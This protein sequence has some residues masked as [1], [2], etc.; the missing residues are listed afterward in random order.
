M[1][2]KDYEYR[3]GIVEKLRAMNYEVYPHKVE[4]THTVKEIVEKQ[5]E[6]MGSKVKTAGRIVGYREHGK[7]IF[8]DIF[9]DGF[10]VQL[11]VKKDVLQEDFK[12]FKNYVQRGDFVWV[13]GEVTKSKRGELS[14][15][16]EEF[17]L[18]CKAL[19]DLPHQWFGLENVETRYRK[20][21][22]DILLN[23]EVFETF[24]KRDLIIKTIR[25]EL[26]AMGFMEVTTPILQPV[27]GGAYAKP[28][29]TYVNALKKEYYL[30]ISPELYLK[31]LL[32][33]GYSKVFE[34]AQNFRNEDIDAEHN[35]EFTMIEIYWAY[36]DYNDMMSLTE[37]LIKKSAES[38]GVKEINF[39]GHKI[40]LRNFRRKDFY[41]LLEEHGIS[42]DISDEKIQQLLKEYKVKIP[43]Y[44]RGYALGKL[45][46]K[47]CEESLIQPTFVI[48]YPQETTPLCKWHRAKGKEIVERF[49][50][51]IGG[52][53]I[54]NGYTELND[55]E[56]QRE[57]FEEEMKRKR[58]GDE[59]AHQYDE[60]FV[61]ALR[62]GMP[63]AGGV[64]I[65]IDRL[66]MILTEKDSIKEVILYPMLAP[67]D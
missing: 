34:I 2:R 49:E 11:M 50:L 46:E 32:V 41:E 40:S 45:F 62:W 51:F 1:V 12:F 38:I 30:R 33:G 31:R 59:E 15:L 47:V 55:P 3:L 23:P 25:S 65:G 22:L 14:I 7:L 28:F 16:V 39:R 56:K 36:A 21:Y 57:L 53:E 54:A 61:E 6:L 48:D 58:L 52:L 10:K 18:I 8:C 5:E 19:Y 63:P 26:W 44:S 13:N 35:P 37:K 42:R 27:Y 24:K 67:R 17:K 64:G 4:V 43:S 20:R 60:E 29:K 9:D 66:V